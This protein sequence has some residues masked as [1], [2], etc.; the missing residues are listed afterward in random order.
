[1]TVPHYDEMFNALLTALH[2]LGGSG[3]N[4]EIE[5]KT[6]KVLGLSEEQ[7][8]EIH[9]GNITKFNYRLAWARTYL[10]NFGLIENSARGIWALT[11]KGNETKSVD[12]VEVNSY[13]KNLKYDKESIDEVVKE[14]EEWKVKLLDKVL[15]M[16]PESFEKLC[17]RILREC[18][19]EK[20][21]VTGRSGDG[22]IDGNGVFKL[23]GLLS[24][25]VAFQCKRWKGN[26]TSKEIRDFRG[27][28]TG[29]TDHG[30][31]IT[32]GNFTGDAKFEASRDGAPKIDLID[33][34][35]LIVKMKELKL[36]IKLE[37]DVDVDGSFF[38]S[39]K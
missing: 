31:F 25:H 23:G 16:P 6:T 33:G 20:V 30:L 7:I 39:F 19:F 27:A 14:E 5:E 21:V 34:D 9:R 35:S 26:I 11:S 17:Q 3:S 2:Q 18:G 10:K 1:M 24:L 22:G 28:M 36:G 15:S 29:R 38:E 8:N 37:E 4:S 13:V 12:K 32:T